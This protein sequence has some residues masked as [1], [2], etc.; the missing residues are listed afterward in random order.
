MV[1]DDRLEMLSVLRELHNISGFRIS[2]HDTKFR[3]IEAY[4]KEISPFC[5][6]IQSCEEGRYSCHENDRRAFEHVS[7]NPEVYLYKCCLGLYE[8]V[9]PLYILGKVVGYLM[10]GQSIDKSK[11]SKETL[12]KNATRLI[13]DKEAIVRA[14]DA[15]HVCDR[16]KILSC[17]KILDICAQYITLSNRFH[18]NKSDITDRI[19][20][21]LDS[22]YFENITIETIC[23]NFFC[24]RTSIM[25]AFK[26]NY[27]V[28][29]I[30][31]LT[32]VRMQTAKR[33]LSNT[34]KTVKEISESCGYSDQNYFSKVFLKHCG[35]TPTEYRKKR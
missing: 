24:S 8:A 5:S 13:S 23:L 26:A 1:Q 4:P 32:H 19:K 20:D 22:H 21:Y 27:G 18:L 7:A 15:V 28:G 35:M 17:M 30:E 16:D 29:I 9:A 12:I 10:M 11:G 31:Y 25:T 2:I 3:E 14:V 6:L 34:E 33:L